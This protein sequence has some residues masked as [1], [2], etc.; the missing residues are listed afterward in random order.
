MKKIYLILF[1]LL[2]NLKVQCQTI[3]SFFSHIDK[4]SIIAK[5]GINLNNKLIFPLKITKETDVNAGLLFLDNDYNISDFLIFNGENNYAINQIISS[6]NNSILIAAE[7]Y[8][9][10]NQESL[11]FLEV[12]NKSIINQFIFNENGNELDPFTLLEF[13]EHKILIGG[14]IKSR[15][16]ISNSFYNMFNEQQMIYAGLFSKDGYKDWSLGLK[17]EGFDKGICNKIIRF[18]NSFILLAHAHHIKGSITPFI[19]KMDEYGNIIKMINLSYERNENILSDIIIHNNVL[20]AVGVINS[21]N[22]QFIYSIEL[23]DQLNINNQNIYTT[24]KRLSLSSIDMRNGFLNI[25]GAA[26]TK[27]NSYNYMFLNEK[28]NIMRSYIFGTNK[29]N[30]LVQNSDDYLIANSFGHNDEYTSSLVLIDNNIIFDEIILSKNIFK[31]SSTKINKYEIVN[32]FQKSNLNPG[33]KKVKLVSNK[34]LMY[35]K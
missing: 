23:D 31:L 18:N 2:I 30:F 21:E 34:E 27:D 24:S 14:F 28:N 10:D 13:N 35:K 22:N 8:S 9:N 32:V 6:K 33:I 20:H 29:F 5:K 3:T 1:C 19:I 26:I 15:E 7:G 17:I 12:F 16:L 25:Y 4:H 11:Y